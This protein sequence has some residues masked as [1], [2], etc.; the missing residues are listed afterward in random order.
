[1][2]TPA[3]PFA[4]KTPYIHHLAHTICKGVPK[5]VNKPWGLKTEAINNTRMTDTQ[6]GVGRTGRRREGKGKQR[7]WFPP[8][9][10]N[11][12]MG[13]YIFLNLSDLPPLNVNC[14]HQLQAHTLYKHT[15]LEFFI[16]LPSFL[17]GDMRGKFPRI[18]WQGLWNKV[19]KMCLTIAC[20][21]CLM[22]PKTCNYSI[23]YSEWIHT[24]FWCCVREAPI[25]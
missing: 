22:K 25:R 8:T 12:L 16:K 7:C 17:A 10:S 6:G 14:V 1:M 9:I 2:T 13:Q 4:F 20:E 5:Q 24:V 18:W 21:R 15:K 3:Y 23:S 11:D 19:L